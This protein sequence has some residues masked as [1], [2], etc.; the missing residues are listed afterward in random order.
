MKDCKNKEH[1][2][3]KIEWECM[4]ADEC[5]Y[6]WKSTCTANFAYHICVRKKI[7]PIKYFSQ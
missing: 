7:T 4:K 6:C 2:F 5:K 1:S 3:Q